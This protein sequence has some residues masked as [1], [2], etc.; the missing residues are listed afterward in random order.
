M[1]WQAGRWRDH[2]KIMPGMEDPLQSRRRGGCLT[3]RNNIVRHRWLRF[4][5]SY[6]RG[7]VWIIPATR[8][9]DAVYTHAVTT[10]PSNKEGF[11]ARGWAGRLALSD[12]TFAFF[13]ARIWLSNIQCSS[14]IE[15][16]LLWRQHKPDWRHIL[17]RLRQCCALS[18]YT[19]YKEKQKTTSII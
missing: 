10:T 18:I 11:W 16:T 8:E 14:K 19:K 5:W 3:R 6:D 15:W 17:F 1:K 4:S 12:I 2:G 13:V 9:P 7:V